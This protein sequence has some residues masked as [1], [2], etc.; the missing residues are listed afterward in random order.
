M[1]GE[2]GAHR[3]GPGLVRAFLRALAPAAA[4]EPLGGQERRQA[5]GSGCREAVPGGGGLGHAGGR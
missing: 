5:G 4:G 3:V 1:A 2:A